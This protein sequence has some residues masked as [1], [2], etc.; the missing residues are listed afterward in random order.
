MTDTRLLRILRLL[1]HQGEDEITRIEQQLVA[2]RKRAWFAA[3]EAE[4]RRWGYTGPASAPRLEDLAWIRR[5]SRL[6]AESI[7][8]TWNR[9][10]DRN[11]DKLYAQNYRGN[12]YYYRY[13]MEPWAAK[14]DVWKGRQ[15]AM[16][17]EMSTANYTR[18]RFEAMNGLRGGL[19]VFTGPPP[20]CG[21]CIWLYGLGPVDQKMADRYPCPRHI[22][23]THR[24]EKLVGSVKAPAPN[25]LWV[26]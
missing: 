14:R 20:V 22:G 3:M 6:D 25:E 26:G 2:A 12:R 11:L 24:W 16:Q 23:C 5:E 4:A 13:H 15:I 21:E 1:Y 17:T 10:V 7:V 19:S 18:Q 8:K 9:D